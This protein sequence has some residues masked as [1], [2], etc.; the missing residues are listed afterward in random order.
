M[1]DLP[2]TNADLRKAAAEYKADDYNAFEILLDMADN[3]PWCGLDTDAFN[4]AH[5]RIATLADAA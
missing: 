1:T 5:D 3:A 4:E 2:Y